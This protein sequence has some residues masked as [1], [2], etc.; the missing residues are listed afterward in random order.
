[1]KRLIAAVG[2]VAV[3]LGLVAI[4][5]RHFQRPLVGLGMAVGFLILPYTRIALIDSGQLVAAALIVLAVAAYRRPAL[6][7]LALAVAGAWM[8]PVA[9]LLPAWA[10]FYRGRGLRLFLAASVPVLV[11]AW[12]VAAAVPAASELALACGARSLAEVGLL[13]TSEVPDG[14]SFWNGVVPAYRLPVVVLHACVVALAFFW[15]A[16]K[17]LGHLIALSALLLASSEFWYLDEGGTHAVLYLP[18]LLMMTFSPNLSLKRP[19]EPAPRRP[20]DA[21]A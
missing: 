4:G 19:P 1:V 17:N 9:G 15:P 7:G 12:L 8:P 10:G 20:A 3:T 5:V 18:L 14:E 6:A 13:P 16:E 21:L 2:H 11:A